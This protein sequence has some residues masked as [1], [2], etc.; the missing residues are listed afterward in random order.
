MYDVSCTHYFCNWLRAF[1]ARIFLLQPMTH[2]LF[3]AFQ[4]P[5]MQ[6]LEREVPLG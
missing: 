5:L 6:A 4:R 1:D 3:V 2:D